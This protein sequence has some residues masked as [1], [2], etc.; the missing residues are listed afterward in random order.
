MTGGAGVEPGAWGGRRSRAAVGAAACRAGG[1]EGSERREREKRARRAVK[2]PSLPSARDL[3]LGK[4]FFKIFKNK[5]CQVPDL[6]HSAKTPLLSA[7]SRA[8][9]KDVFY[10]LCRV[11]TD[12]HSAKPSLPSANWTALG[13]VYFIFFIFGNQTFYG[14]FLHYVDLQVPFWYNYK[15]VFIASRFSSFI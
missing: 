6:G 1:R 14:V 12:R 10:R 15:S 11:P 9:G 7:S 5:L 3:A 2:L 13:K 4:D 8:L